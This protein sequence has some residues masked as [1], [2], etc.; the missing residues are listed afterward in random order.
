MRIGDAFHRLVVERRVE[1]DCDGR[2]GFVALLHGELDGGAEVFLGAGVMHGGLV[3]TGFADIDAPGDCVVFARPVFEEGVVRGLGAANDRAVRNA[4][5]SG[6]GGRGGI[7]DGERAIAIG[8]EILLH[9]RVVPSGELGQ[10]RVDL[11]VFRRDIVVLAP[12]GGDVEELAGSIEPVALI[13]HTDLLVFDAEYGAVVPRTG[14]TSEEGLETLTIDRLGRGNLCAGEFG[15]RGQQVDCC[16]DLRH[17][18]ASGDLVRPADEERRTQAAFIDGAFAAFHA[19]VP[20][21]GVGSIVREI[22]DDGIVLQIQFFEPLE[23][24]ADIPVNVLAHREGGAGHHHVLA[25][26]FAVHHGRV[27][28]SEF[29]VE[30]VANHHRG[31][32][33]VVGQVAE[34]RIVAIVFDEFQRVVGEVVDHEAVAPNLAAIVIERRAEVV[35][36]VSGGESVVFVEATIVGVIGGLGAVV[37]FAECAGGV[38]VGLKHVGDGGLVGIKPTLSGTDSTHAG[39]RIVAA[40]EEFGAGRRTHLADIEIVECCPVAGEGIDVRRGEV[41][42]PANAQITPA[43][44]VG[45]DDDDVGLS[46]GKNARA[47]GNVQGEQTEEVS[48][49]LDK[50]DGGAVRRGEQF[51]NLAI[52]LLSINRDLLLPRIPNQRG[53][54]SGSA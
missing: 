4:V 3:F 47:G 33:R 18:E 46:S 21:N 13:T 37:P 44:I 35:A 52:F 40:G 42:V 50:R 27:D 16:G 19:A 51:E 43:L 6:Q 23:D 24:T 41:G 2:G 12:V 38:A 5:P 32:R 14:L 22:D 1:R 15:Q 29:V 30:L 49:G 10:S 39:A 20:T 17:A 8:G 26:W 25:L 34:E 11:R 9:R 28:V 54:S 31:M 48:H 7:T 53:R 36:P 45:E